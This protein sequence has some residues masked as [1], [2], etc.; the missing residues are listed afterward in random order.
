[1]KRDEKLIINKEVVPWDYNS[2]Q[3]REYTKFRHLTLLLTFTEKTIIISR[4][5]DVGVNCIF[6]STTILK[7]QPDNPDIFARLASDMQ[8]KELHAI[9]HSDTRSVGVQP[10]SV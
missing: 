5:F 1:M 8:V 10:F 4:L 6:V 7:A 2:N 3:I 9:V